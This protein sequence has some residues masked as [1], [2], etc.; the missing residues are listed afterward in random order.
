MPNTW[1]W[2]KPLPVSLFLVGFMQKRV[3]WHKRVKR[4]FSRN[5]NE[6]LIMEKLV[7]N[8]PSCPSEEGLLYQLYQG[9]PLLSIYRF[10][11]TIFV[12]LAIVE[13]R[14]QIISPIKNQIIKSNQ[15]VLFNCTVSLEKNVSGT[16][17][18]NK[19]GYFIPPAKKSKHWASFEIGKYA[20]DFLSKKARR[21][22]ET[23]IW[24]SN[25]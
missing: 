8:C 5:P 19:D 7:R 21:V 14:V 24:S 16:I 6:S 3:S 10:S 22:L 1:T 12:G 25:T 15:S 9:F 2:L 23:L 18:W 11:F 17:Q 4:W 20:S 13:P